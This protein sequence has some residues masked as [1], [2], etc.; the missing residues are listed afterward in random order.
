MVGGAV[1]GATCNCIVV[2]ALEV[3]RHAVIVR[4]TATSGR[5]WAVY[6]V[7]PGEIIPFFRPRD[8]QAR[9]HSKQADAALILV[10][11]QIACS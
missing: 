1:G 2:V 6:T 5:P 10:T 7:I 11:D 4:Q 9:L 3:R 8:E